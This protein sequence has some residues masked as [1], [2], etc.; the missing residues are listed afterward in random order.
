MT[1]ARRARG[2]ARR[3]RGAWLLIAIPLLMLL[4]GTLIFLGM[5]RQADVAQDP[6]PGASTTAVTTSPNATVSTPGGQPTPTGRPTRTGQSN[7]PAAARA[8]RACRAKV[9]AGDRVL[10]VAKTGMQNWSDHI[11]AQTDANAGKI[12]SKEMQDIFDRTMKAG[13]ED[14][15]RYNGALKRYQDQD[16]RCRKVPGASAEVTERL[17]RCAQRGR[18]QEPVL[19]AAKDGMDD[20]IR[21]LDDMRRSSQGMLHDAQRKWLRTW[22]AAPKN[23]NAYQDAA[24]EFSAP[25]C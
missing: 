11:Q 24:E 13:D 5:R 25:K 6:M 17:A 4:A 18:A 14:E 21:H 23:I 8:L 16:G 7:D 12:T 2:S 19:A 15:R 1:Q 9:A 10:A 3:R 20:W 22:R